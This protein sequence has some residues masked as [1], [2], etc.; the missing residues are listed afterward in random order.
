[1]NPHNVI[2][3]VTSFN[4]PREPRHILEAQQV[5]R[6]G[7][8]LRAGEWGS[9]IESVKIFDSSSLCLECSPPL[10]ISWRVFHTMVLFDL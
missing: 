7:K 4:D 9:W 8:K 2:E 6:C 1:M 10:P 3:V 5:T